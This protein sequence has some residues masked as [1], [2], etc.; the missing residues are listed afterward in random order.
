[1]PVGIMLQHVVRAAQALDRLVAEDLVVVGVN[2]VE[3]P[4]PLWWLR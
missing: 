3:D 1:V 2:D 4:G